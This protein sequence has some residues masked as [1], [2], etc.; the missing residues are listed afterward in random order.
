MGKHIPTMTIKNKAQPPWFDSE[1]FQL[2]RK[3]ERL[4]SK[5]KISGSASDY[6]AYS[7]CR[8]EFKIL[9]SDKMKANIYDEEDPSLVSKKFWAHL[10]ATS[11][12][13]RIPESV[14]Y[15]R[16]FRNN[17]KDQT[18]LFNE[19]FTDQF[20]E[21]SEYNI[22]I[23]FYRDNIDNTI[24]FSLY[25]I[26]SLLKKVKP[27]KAPG[28]DGINGIVL[29][30]CAVSLAYPLSKLY[31]LSYN[32]GIIPNEWKLSCVVPVHKKGSKSTV[33]DYS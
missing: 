18:E 30:K 19:Y 16:R 24:D 22:D 27:K 21:P 32:T 25:R 13:T 14:S 17:P 5:F 26:R 11:K 3:K 1:A 4:R 23:D 29:K 12:S 9:I 7:K 10:K 31:K 8:K 6:S 15:G 2:C 20:S 33:E 28:P